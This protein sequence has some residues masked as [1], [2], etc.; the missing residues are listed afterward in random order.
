MGWVG[1]FKTLWTLLLCS[2]G[3]SIASLVSQI[4]IVSGFPLFH[5]CRWLGKVILRFEKK[6][7][8]LWSKMVLLSNVL[9]NDYKHTLA[10]LS[11]FL[12][13]SLPHL[14]VLNFTQRVEVSRL[15]LNFARG[16][17]FFQ[18]I[19]LTSFF[20]KLPRWYSRVELTTLKILW[21]NRIQAALVNCGLR[22]F[23]FLLFTDC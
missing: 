10:M 17:I 19:I 3:Q 23:I 16:Q 14:R 22:T 20:L 4:I 9:Q 12:L 2:F 15:C 6:L 5:F 13:V 8:K 1:L 21:Q 7:L 11:L 18:T